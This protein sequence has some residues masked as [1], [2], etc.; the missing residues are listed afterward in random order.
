MRVNSRLFAALAAAS[1]F[2]A[3]CVVGVTPVIQYGPLTVELGPQG[4]GLA[5]E[6]TVSPVPAAPQLLSVV[7]LAGQESLALIAFFPSDI[8]DYVIVSVAATPTGAAPEPQAVQVVARGGA[9]HSV[10]YD[11]PKPVAAGRCFAQLT[12]AKGRLKEHRP[13][14]PLTWHEPPEQVTLSLSVDLPG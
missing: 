7:G 1:V 11:A 12:Y 2:G 4:G 8:W 6:P 13:G 14:A 9:T 3:G 10:V 5:A